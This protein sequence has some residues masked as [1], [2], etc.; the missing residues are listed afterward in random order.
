[1][2]VILYCFAGIVKFVV[3]INDLIVIFILC[4][5]GVMN[6]PIIIFGSSRSDGHT[7][8]VID[9]LC[10]NR[11]VPMVDLARLRISHYD[12]QYKNQFDDYFPLIQRMIQYS[13][14]F[15]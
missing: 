8:E 1:M 5:Y 14:Y 6:Q 4:M 15:V 7:K 2:L 10:V 9:A 12:Y 3:V 13:Q 11:A